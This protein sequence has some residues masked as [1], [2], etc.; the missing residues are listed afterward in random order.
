MG[1]KYQVGV[2]VTEVDLQ[3]PVVV[4]ALKLCGALT[5]KDIENGIVSYNEKNL[6]KILEKC[7]GF[8]NG[9]YEA[10]VFE[11]QKSRFSDGVIKNKIRYTGLERK[12]KEW[13]ESGMASKEVLEIIKWGEPL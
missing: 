7:F 11:K 6:P 1:S 13:A 8:K 4:R 9:E 3:N 10:T 2:F 5:E 12:D